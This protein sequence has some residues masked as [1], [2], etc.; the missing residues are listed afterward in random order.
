MG[1]MT[2][3]SIA[4]NRTGKLELGDQWGLDNE[5]YKRFKHKKEPSPIVRLG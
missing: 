1:F 2:T 5:I 3:I 4:G